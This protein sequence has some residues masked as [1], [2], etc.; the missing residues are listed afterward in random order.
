[1]SLRGGTRRLAFAVLPVLA[2]AGL[3]GLGSRRAASTYARLDKP[4]WA[5]PGSVFG[6]V[7]T[8]LYATLAVAGWRTYDASPR[9]RG[10]HLAQLA[11]NAAWPALFFGIREKRASLM[12]IS[13][14]DAT[15]ALEAATLRHDDRLA[16]ALLAPYL[17]W[18]GYATALNAAVSDP[19]TTA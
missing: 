18:C 16:A 2:A 10:L 12:L 3:G 4:R 7:W 17:A 14:L 1:M 8:A 13:A 5:P 6:P 15:V 9:A 11:L 19:T